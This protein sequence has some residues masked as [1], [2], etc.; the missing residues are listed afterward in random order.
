MLER[1]TKERFKEIQR[2]LNLTPLEMAAALGK[3]GRTVYR[4]LSGEQPIPETV[5][6]LLEAIIKENGG[7]AKYWLDKLKNT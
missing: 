2:I 5:K 4:Y 1:M 7:C 6:L 3:D